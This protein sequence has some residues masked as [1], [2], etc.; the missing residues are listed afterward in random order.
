MLT[1]LLIIAARSSGTDITSSLRS[2]IVDNS[3]GVISFAPDSIAL[4]S[5]ISGVRWAGWL[6]K[7]ATSSGS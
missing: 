3:C 2:R 6:S 1:I 4:R 5:A 7:E